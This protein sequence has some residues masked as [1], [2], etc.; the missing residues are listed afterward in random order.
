MAN[1]TIYNGDANEIT[2]GVQGHEVRAMAQEIANTRGESVWYGDDDGEDLLWEQLT[3]VDPSEV[4]TPDAITN[5]QIRRLSNEAGEHGDLDMV[6]IC[7][8]ALAGDE[9]ARAECARAI[10]DAAAMA[11]V[12]S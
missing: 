5:G 11:E 10:A 2:A 12:Q 4:Q 3:R 7:D 6:A 1:Y 9:S 8:R